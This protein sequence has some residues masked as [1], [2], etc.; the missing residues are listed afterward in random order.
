MYTPEFDKE[1]LKK[2]EG[3]IGRTLVNIKMKTKNYQTHLR[4]LDKCLC[5]VW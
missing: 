3:H 1:D 4:N 5:I 2:A